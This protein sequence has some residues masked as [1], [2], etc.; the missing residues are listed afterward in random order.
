M[1]QDK[2]EVV[3]LIRCKNITLGRG[4]DA[5]FSGA[6]FDLCPGDRMAVVGESGCGKSSL[7]SAILGQKDIS[8]TAGQ[9]DIGGFPCGSKAALRWLAENAGVMFQ[10]DALF[11][12]ESVAYNLAFPLRF[13]QSSFISGKKV[14]LSEE[15]FLNVLREVNLEVTEQELKKAETSEKK[16]IPSWKVVLAGI[17]RS[18]SLLSMLLLGCYIPTKKKILTTNVDELSGGQK[19]RVALARVLALK[20][21]FLLLDEPTSGLDKPTATSI[22][23]RIK[24]YADDTGVAILCVTHDEDFSKAIGCNLCLHI[25]QKDRSCHLQKFERNSLDN[26][27]KPPMPSTIKVARRN[28]AHLRLFGVESSRRFIHILCSGGLIC[29]IVSLL[30]GAGIVSQSIGGPRWIQGFIPQGLT[31]GVFLGLGTIIPALLVIGLC[32]SAIV[33]ELVQRKNTDQLTYLPLIG[34]HPRNFL[35]FPIVLGLAIALPL[36]T[37]LSEYLMLQGGHLAW[38]CFEQISIVDRTATKFWTLVWDKIEPD[39]WF[40][41]GIK[42]LTH[43][44]LIGSVVCWFGFRSKRGDSALRQSVAYGVLIS[45]ILV[46]VADLAWSLFFLN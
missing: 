41:S 37:L 22:A 46:I 20:P 17:Q 29:V 18:P 25:D 40:R 15:S 24:K 12:G 2:P 10:R 5:Y 43:G 39:M 33:A 3:P 13:S 28:L 4:G 8:I 9:L 7:F 31:A 14:Q 35:G 36:L 21:L 45:S 19:K 23:G 26:H 1:V 11:D 27:T 6:T 44:I 34:I 32:A 42:G 38:S 30:A 16:D